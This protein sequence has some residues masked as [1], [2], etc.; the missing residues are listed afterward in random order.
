MTMRML[1]ATEI[2]VEWDG[3]QSSDVAIPH[4]NS[5][6]VRAQNSYPPRHTA[7]RRINASL[8]YGV[9]P[10]RSCSRPCLLTPLRRREISSFFYFWCKKYYLPDLLRKICLDAYAWGKCKVGKKGE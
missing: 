1:L 9:S 6:C 5:A 2:A 8:A 10:P 4:M 7:L 3:V